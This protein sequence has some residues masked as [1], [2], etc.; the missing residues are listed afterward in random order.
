MDSKLEKTDANYQ[1]L[2]PVSFLVKAAEVYP[3]KKSIIYNQIH[4]TWL[5]TFK[6]CKQLASAFQ[7]IGLSK[8]DVIGFMAT[9][10]PE[11][12]EAHFSVPMAGMVLNT[13]NYRLDA[14]TIAYII[15]HSEIKLLVT[16]KE[17]SAVITTALKS[18]K[19][20][21]ILIDIDDPYG[22]GGDLLGE[23]NYEKFLTTGSIDFQIAEPI[24]EWDTISINYTSGTTGSPK[25]VV[26][27]YR[28][29]Y[30]NS[31]GNVMEWDMIAHPVYLWTLPM[32]HCNGW[33]F[34][35]TIAAKVGTNICVR[36]VN[37]EVIFDALNRYGVTHLC[38]APII[39]GMMVNATLS[40]KKDFDQTCKV[41]TAAAPPPARVLQSMQESGFEVTHVYGL[42][43]VYGPC[44]VSNWQ[45]EWSL[46]DGGKQANLKA[47]QGNAYLVQEGLRVVNIG[48]MTDVPKDG[49]TIGEVLLRGNIMMKG[50]LKNSSATKAA[51]KSGWFHTGDLGVLHADGYLQLKDRAKDIIISG[52]ENI[53]SIEIED[54]L[55]LLDEVAS[56]GV[57]AKSDDIWGEVPCA[58]IELKSEMNVTKEELVE[59]CRK[60]LAGFKV[61][62]EFIF[63]EIPK[64][65][66]GKI[67]KA[68]LRKIVELLD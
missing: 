66:T 53:S 35:W 11:L 12:Y 64:T 50:Y 49:E 24:D 59:H 21:P 22:L 16:D 51:F 54:C 57:V 8:G 15:D 62:K 44:V 55:Y 39:L 28:G 32:F 41:M 18:C 33:C 46:L 26:Y 13:L 42:T 61:P 58:F 40:E 63:Q 20:K 2:N 5:E 30:L 68:E 34:P 25:G 3:D 10:T 1:A 56:C 43:E 27:H 31:L 7:N 36:K 17:F 60:N 65:S 6:R 52:G 19:N 23:F 37:A 45:D 67:Q 14:Q 47:R 4:F 9:N 38:G 29:A 48:T